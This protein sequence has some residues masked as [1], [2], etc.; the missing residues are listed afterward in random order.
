MTSSLDE[1]QQVYDHIRR[2]TVD[3]RLAKYTPEELK[4]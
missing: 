2:A 4:E 3:R 1:E